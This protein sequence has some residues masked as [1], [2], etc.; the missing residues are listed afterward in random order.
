EVFVCADG[1]LRRRERVAPGGFELQHLV[2]LPGLHTTEVVVRD[3]LGNEQRI[4]DPYYYSE[5]LLR[6]GIDEYSFDLG[7]ERQQYGLRSDDYGKPAF[8]AFYRRG[9]T[10]GFTLGG[11]AEA[12][13]RRYNFGPSATW[14]L[15]LLGVATA[16]FAVGGTERASGRAFSI[17]HAFHSYR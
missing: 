6:P 5:S 4:V 12:L 15:G 16:A 14:S 7:F 2:N 1:V 11:H 3:V 8:A 13:E 17:S 10:P 9:L